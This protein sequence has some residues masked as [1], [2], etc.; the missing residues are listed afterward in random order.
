MY[1]FSL[2]RYYLPL[3]K[4]VALHLNRLESSSPKNALRQLWL[5][6][7]QLF[8]RRWFLNFVNV[9]SLFPYYLPLKK[10]GALYLNT[11]ESSSPKD[12]LCQVWLKL[13]Q[14]FWRRIFFN[15]VN[16]FSLF[17][18][19]LLLE[20]EVCFY[21][22]FRVRKCYYAFHGINYANNLTKSHKPVFLINGMPCKVVVHLQKEMHSIVEMKRWPK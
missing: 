14:W 11:L 21:V 15:F 8:W 19:N 7:A 4:G 17:R 1:V 2:F 5:K 9:F 13:A 3:E 20:K 22:D 12:A 18:Y 6:L 16:V 10:G